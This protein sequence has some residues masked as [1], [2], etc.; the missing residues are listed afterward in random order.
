MSLPAPA[1]SASSNDAQASR[2]IF[3]LSSHPIA[4]VFFLAFRTGAILTYI[5]GL[6]FTSNFILIFI[7]IILLLAFDFWT[8]KNVA[9]RLLVGLRWWNETDETGASIWLFESANE[10]VEVNATDQRV[11]WGVLYGTPVIWFGLA[12]IAI[13]KFE[14]VW[15][16]LVVI[17]MILSGANAMAYT[18]CDKDAKKKWANSIASQAS[19]GFV[20]RMAGN[21]ASRLFAF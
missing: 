10:S 18:R 20:R 7:L 1:T 14:F 17:A 8:V 6:I 2:H 4:L 21:A 12:F 3:Q 13:I 16:T 9:G 15:L 11:F 19:S 5:L